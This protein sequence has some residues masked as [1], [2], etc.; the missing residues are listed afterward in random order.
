MKRLLF[1]FAIM[2]FASAA[3]T[4]AWGEP[5]EQ[6]TQDF[7][8]STIK[9]CAYASHLHGVRFDGSTFHLN[10]KIQLFGTEHFDIERSVPVEKLK[11]A[12]VDGYR[13]NWVC[14]AHEGKCIT[15][16]I[17]EN[18]ETLREYTAYSTKCPDES[19]EVLAKAFNHL[20]GIYKAQRPKPPFEVD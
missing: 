3:A 8:V 14:A 1:S 9:N 4:T 11:E 20:I 6:D 13:V 2:L 10:T 12:F 18:S 19:N 7:I 17:A 15:T 5:T 16:V